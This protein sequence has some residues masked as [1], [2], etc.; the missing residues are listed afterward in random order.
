MAEAFKNS[1]GLEFS[2]FYSKATAR[3]KMLQEL[4]GRTVK[5]YLAGQGM[6]TGLTFMGLAEPI[7]GQV[8]EVRDSWLKIQTQKE[9]EFLNLRKIGRISTIQNSL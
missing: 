9:V 7:K 6:M 1:V 2:Q 8:V 5:V 3:T 4:V